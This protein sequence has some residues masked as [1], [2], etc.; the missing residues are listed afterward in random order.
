MADHGG[1]SASEWAVILTAAAGVFAAVFKAIGGAAA[2]LAS[3]TERQASRRET[4]LNR[5]HE[6]LVEREHDLQAANEKFQKD[7]RQELETIK[8]QMR[9][10]NYAFQ[11]VSTELR[12]KDPANP[13]LRQADELL[14]AAF[15]IDLELPE[16]MLIGLARIEA[17]DRAK[18]KTSP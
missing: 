6:E 16:D 7:L 1:P 18:G 11:L 12:V 8:A 4:K 14:R 10:V 15:K 2:W 13:A 9:A 3:S 5:W 17:A